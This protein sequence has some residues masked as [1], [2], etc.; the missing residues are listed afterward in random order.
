MARSPSFEKFK[1]NSPCEIAHASIYINKLNTNIKN[2]LC[3]S[4]IDTSYQRFKSRLNRL[5][6]SKWKRNHLIEISIFRTRSIKKKRKII[7][8]YYIKLHSSSS[9]IFTILVTL[10]SNFKIITL[11]TNPPSPRL[12]NKPFLNQTLPLP[13]FS[14]SRDGPISRGPKSEMGDTRD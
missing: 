6:K 10:V 2:L 7:E 11:E 5:W 12:L 8:K 14:R 4:Y 1:K 13:L 3:R 9:N